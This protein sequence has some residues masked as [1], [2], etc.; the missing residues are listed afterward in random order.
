MSPPDTPPDTPPSSLASNPQLPK[1]IGPDAPW[2]VLVLTLPGDEARRA[3]LLAALEQAQIP[4]WLFFG[5]DGRKGLPAAYEPQ[6]DRPRAEARMGRPMGNGEFACALSHRALYQAIVARGWP[7]A[8]ILED[9]ALLRPGF[10]PF[11]AGRG[12]LASDMVMLDH[13]AARVARGSARALAGGQAWRLLLP[14]LLTTGYTISAR[15]AGF[16]LAQTQPLA[17]TADWP[18]DIT[19]LGALAMDPPA[20]GHPDE[21]AGPSHLRGERRRRVAPWRFFT[22]GYWRRWWAKRRAYRLSR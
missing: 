17:G 3:P 6:I 8:V 5:V 1:A 12:Y 14:S 10:A 9:D 4:A 20:I 7:G 11:L 15:G 21:A 18:C 13:R 2:P 16:M 22:L 19:R